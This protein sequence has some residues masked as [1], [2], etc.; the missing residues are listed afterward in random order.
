[1]SPSVVRVSATLHATSLSFR[2]K[3]FLHEKLP[4]VGRR[5]NTTIERLVYRTLIIL[6]DTLDDTILRWACPFDKGQENRVRKINLPPRFF[7]EPM[8]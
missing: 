2:C 6:F 7:F 1:M 5:P 3:T 8:L 4:K